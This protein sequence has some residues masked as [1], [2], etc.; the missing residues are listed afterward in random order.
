MGNQKNSLV[1][2]GVL[3]DSLT[4]CNCPQRPSYFGMVFLQMCHIKFFF[5]NTED[6]SDL[7]SSAKFHI[8][9]ELSAG[10]MFSLAIVV[11][12]RT[13]NKSD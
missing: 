12:W 6:W 1:I 8:I 13:R 11:D 9:Y 10:G 4:F 7:N 2:S 5:P 3:C